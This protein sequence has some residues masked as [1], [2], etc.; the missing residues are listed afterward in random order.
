MKIAIKEVLNSAVVAGNITTDQSQAISRELSN[1]LLAKENNQ[2]LANATGKPKPDVATT[3]LDKINTLKSN[4]AHAQCSDTIPGC[5]RFKDAGICPFVA[6]FMNGACAKT[7]D[8]CL[9]KTK[10][11]K[12]V[13]I[14]TSLG[15]AFLSVNFLQYL[16]L[17]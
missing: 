17:N 5:T 1:A 8:S 4:V 9:P 2:T 10:S 7:C 15:L 11:S 3:S 12:H 16:N 6:T 14:S 13:K